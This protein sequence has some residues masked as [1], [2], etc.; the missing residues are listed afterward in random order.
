[1]G[2]YLILL[3]ITKDHLGTLAITCAAVDDVTAWSLLAVVI[4]IVKAGSF[5]SDL[6]TIALA[7]LY[8][9]VMLKLFRPFLK[10]IGDVN[11]EKTHLTK[12]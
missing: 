9:I 10:R 8:V 1:M 11:A 3:S 4:A 6:Y 2:L 12:R 5:V 7:A